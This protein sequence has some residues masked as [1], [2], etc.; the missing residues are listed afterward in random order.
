MSGDTVSI[1]ISLVSLVIAL[2]ASVQH[3]CKFFVYHFYKLKLEIFFP[4][5][6]NTK[7]KFS[8]LENTLLNIHLKDKRPLKVEIEFVLDKPWKLKQNMKNIIAE[9]G[10]GK[11]S[12]GMFR[13]RTGSFNLPGCSTLAIQFPFEPRNEECVVE[14]IVYPKISLSELRLPRYFGE[15]DLKPVSKVFYIIT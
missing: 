11:G 5:A 13:F 15:V 2:I 4:N 12:R 1:I 9:S 7:I 10:L 14:I 8:D 6:E 3:I